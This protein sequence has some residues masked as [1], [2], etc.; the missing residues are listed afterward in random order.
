MASPVESLRL[1]YFANLH[2]PLSVAALRE[3]YLQADGLPDAFADALRFLRQKDLL[4]KSEPV[5][6]TSKGLRTL[7]SM[8]NFKDRDAGRLFVLKD[9]LKAGTLNKDKRSEF[10]TARG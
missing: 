3:L 6:C 5:Y 10:E 7:Q 8:P 4:S 1:L 2:Q 9:Q